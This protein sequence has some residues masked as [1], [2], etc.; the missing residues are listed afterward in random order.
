MVQWLRLHSLNVGGLGSIS[1]QGTISQV[2]QLRASLVAQMVKNPTAMWE[3][4]IRS[5]GWE[6]SGLGE[7]TGYPLQYSCLDNS[8]DRE[9]WQ[10]I[11]YGVAKSQTQLSD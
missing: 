9:A 8:R 11:V 5:L 7:G 10:P 2:L 1:G 6:D 4:W 3:T